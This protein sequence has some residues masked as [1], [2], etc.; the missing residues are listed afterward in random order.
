MSNKIL[1]RKSSKSYGLDIFIGGDYYVAKQV[2]RRYCMD[3]GFCVSITQTDF[4]YT[5]G[6]ESGVRIGIVQYPRF[7]KSNQELWN[8]ARTL[9]VK[10]MEELCQTSFLIQGPDN[11]EWFSR[12][13]ED[14]NY[15]SR[16]TSKGK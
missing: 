14:T 1:S 16:D 9:G 11:T 10:L 7:E 5:G 12:R 3:F 2:C 15:A 13:K 4:I 6:E 8:H